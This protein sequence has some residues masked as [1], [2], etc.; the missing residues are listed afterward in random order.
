MI[1]ARGS[2]FRML[3]A[4][5]RP[6]SSVP[7]RMSRM[8]TSGC[9]AAYSATAS[10]GVLA[11]PTTCMPAASSDMANPVMTIGWS[12]ASMTRIGFFCSDTSFTPV[13]HLLTFAYQ[14]LAGRCAKR[15]KAC[16][17]YRDYFIQRAAT[18]DPSH[19]PA[20]HQEDLQLEAK[21]PRNSFTH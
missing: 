14:S 10:L 4:A 7:K 16:D 15:Q 5:S 21:L 17:L 18:R 19:S 9:C 20:F 6:V 1:L 13:N 12:S 8:T 3:C 2:S 11:C